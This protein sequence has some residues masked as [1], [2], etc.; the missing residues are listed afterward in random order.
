[1]TLS[2]PAASARLIEV[3]P[4][5]QG[6]GI[7]LG[8]PHLFVRFWDCN[9][10]CRY[11]DT[12]YKGLFRERDGEELLA[13]VRERVGREGPFD[14][15]SLTGGEPLLWAD[16][17]A[18]WLPRL[19]GLGPRIYLETNGTLPEALNRLGE[20]IDIVAMDLKP[21]SATGDR[22][23]WAEHEAF[24]DA[25]RRLNLELFIKLIVTAGTDDG[26]VERAFRLVAERDPGIPVVL[27][28]VT[29]HGPVKETPTSDR[30]LAWQG[31]G[32]RLLR[33]VRILPQV[34]KLLG[35]P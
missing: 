25:A 1:M 22:A 3:F 34:H 9:L 32:R 18:G 6:E 2:A 13:E 15:I 10:A 26:E 7:Y 28:P 21:P 4:S 35:V 12:P 30:L 20:W 8:R 29:P 16:F 33:D 17:L 14:A 24:L 27:Q 23:V 19:R 5:I 11:C 31:T